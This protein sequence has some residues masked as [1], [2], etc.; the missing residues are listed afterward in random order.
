MIIV[1]VAAFPLV[2]P[3]VLLVVAFAQGQ[4]AQPSS[5]LLTGLLLG[6]F[7]VPILVGL[8]ILITRTGQFTYTFPGGS[9]SGE[10]FTPAH[11]GLCIALVVVD[12]VV[13]C[14]AARLSPV[15]QATP[16]SGAMARA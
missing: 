15:G 8:W 1:S 4:N 9:E 14:V 5:P 13:A 7:P 16:K 6:G 11:A 3:C 2:V 12:V 10:Y